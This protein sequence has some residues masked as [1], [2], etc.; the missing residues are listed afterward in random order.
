MKMVNHELG[1]ERGGKI[2]TLAQKLLNEGQEVGWTGGEKNTSEKIARRLLKAGVEIA[3][4]AK[5]T[6]LSLSQLKEFQA[7]LTTQA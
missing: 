6:G 3:F 1:P 2:M 5:M 4:V 7:D